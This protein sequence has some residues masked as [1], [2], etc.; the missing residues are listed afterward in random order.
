[1][2]LTTDRV[3]DTRT[4]QLKELVR[5]LVDV[6]RQNGGVVSQRDAMRQAAASS[7]LSVSEM[8]Y[9]VNSAVADRMITADLRSGKL[10]L[11]E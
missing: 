5:V 7:G 4:Q 9:I 3:A 2:T 11:V 1:M 8:P 10:Q 6:V